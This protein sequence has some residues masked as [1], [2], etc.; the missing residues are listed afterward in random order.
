[1]SM[2]TACFGAGTRQSLYEDCAFDGTK[3]SA[4]APGIAKFV[5]CTFKNVDI[6]LFHGLEVSM[7]DCV[8][9]GA[10]RGVVFYGRRPGRRRLFWRR[11]N[12][13]FGNDFEAAS[14]DDVVFR[15]AIDLSLQKFPIGW[16]HP[17]DAYNE[18]VT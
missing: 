10:L 3:F 13:F 4:P 11:K 9:S 6:S 7:V 15:E 14:L 17:C 2:T 1:M 5:R 16:K 18:L 12:D 8:F